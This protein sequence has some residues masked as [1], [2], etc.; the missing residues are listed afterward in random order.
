MLKKREAKKLDRENLWAYALK[1][2][3]QRAQTSSEIRAKLRRKAAEPDD[4][5][6]TLAKLKEYG[7]LDDRRFAE[8]FAEGRLTNQGFGSGRAMRDLF[9]RRVAPALAE[10]SVQKVYAEQ[11]EVALIEAYIRRKYRTASRETLFAEEKDMASAFR[12]LRV[13]GFSTGNVVKVLKR[14]AA[15]PELLDGLEECEE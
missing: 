11:D 1:S 5:D 3:G 10:Q 13:A 12:R 8:N 7:F 6:L 2:V 14:F 15:K 9:A 4:V